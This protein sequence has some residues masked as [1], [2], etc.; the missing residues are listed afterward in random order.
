MPLL[1]GRTFFDTIQRGDYPSEQLACLCDDDLISILLTYVV[2]IYHHRE[3][4]GAASPDWPF[5]RPSAI[6]NGEGQ[7]RATSLPSRFG[8][9]LIELSDRRDPQHLLKLWNHD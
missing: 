8:Y 6:C 3:R 2:D 5:V 4:C 7:H 9:Y 1:A